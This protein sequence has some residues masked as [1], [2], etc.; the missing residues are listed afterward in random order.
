MKVLKYI[1]L[2]VLLLILALVLVVRSGS[3]LDFLLQNATKS[4]GIDLHYS[5]MSGN[6]WQGLVLED[7]NFENK[8]E[9]KRVALK[10][11]YP[12]LQKEIVH[13][14]N[15]EVLDLH[16]DEHFLQELIDSNSSKEESGSKKPL[17]FPKMVQIDNLDFSLNDTAYRDYRIESLQLHGENIRYD[18]DKKADGLITL[19][20]ATNVADLDANIT[21]DASHYTGRIVLDPKRDYLN[22]LLAE[23]NVT[24]AKAGHMVLDL[25]GDFEGSDFDVKI[26][27]AVLAYGKYMIEKSHI[28]SKGHYDF[29]TTALH[30]QNDIDLGTNIADLHS[31]SIVDLSVND[32]NNTLHFDV[33]LD[34]KGA[35]AELAEILADANLSFVKASDLK[36]HVAGS[37]QE[38]NATLNLKGG[39]VR[40]GAYRLNP[41]FLRIKGYYN[42]AQDLLDAKGGM[43]LRSN[44]ADAK[45]DFQASLSPKAWQKSLDL[46]LTGDVLPKEAFLKPQLLEQ[47]ITL[48][49]ISPLH[50][51][52][53]TRKNLITAKLLLQPFALVKDDLK[54]RSEDLRSDLTFDLDS[55]EADFTLNAPL[56]TNAADLLVDAN[57]S[58]DL[59]DL[60]NTL[61]YKAFVNL[62]A[63]EGY[64][65]KHLKIKRIDLHQLSPLRLDLTGDAKVLDAILGLHGK[66]RVDR[67]RFE[68]DFDN[69]KVHYNIAKKEV[70]S[71]LHIALLSTVADIKLKGRAAFALEDINNTFVHDIDLLLYQREPV[72]DVNLT[73]LG[74]VVLKSKGTLKKSEAILHSKKLNAEATLNDLNRINFTL[75]VEKLRPYELYADLPPTLKKSRVSMDAKGFYEIKS[76]KLELSAALKKL[77]LAGRDISTNRF[78]L[79]YDGK[80]FAMTPL[81]LQAKNFQMILDAKQESDGTLIAHLKN[82]A[83]NADVRFKEKPLFA[84]ATVDIS[85][86]KK[87]LHEVDKVYPIAPIPEVDGKVRLS[88]KMAGNERVKVTLVSPEISFKEGRIED[89]DILAYYTPKRI[90]IPRFDFTLAGFKPKKMN[91]K[92][93]LDHPAYIVLGDDLKVDFALKNFLTIKAE[94]SG[95]LIKGRFTT[96]KLF[97]GL[98]GYGETKLTSDIEL[99]KSGE[100]I[101]VS[102]DVELEETL[103]TYE[104]RVLD[105]SQDPDIIIIKKKRKKKAAD[106]SF[107][108]NVFLDLRIKSKDEIEYK[109]EAGT[110]MLKPNLEVRKDFGSKLK[111]LGKINILEGEYDF[112]D[113]RF[114]LKE[115]AIAFRGL[116]EINPHLDLH[117]E[118][119]IDEVVIYIDILGDKRKPKLQFKS[120]PMMSKK[121]IFSYLLFGFAVSESEGAQSSAANAAEKIFGRALAKDLARELKLD[122]L[123]LTRNQLGGI[124]IKAGKKVNKK[125]IIYYQNK[126]LESSV[127]VERK[128]GKHL[129]LDVE[130]GQESQAVDFV[131]RKGFK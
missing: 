81:K 49:K 109:V 69:T 30:A 16:I 108:K 52:A 95:D 87:L 28:A 120:K 55:Q 39:E 65:Q 91:R 92:V 90:D 76:K 31:S 97:L 23:Q 107:V 21:L 103:I 89:I 85:S 110:I 123:D 88:A 36:L 126:S 42:L 102:G 46:N 99:Y 72:M 32:I 18:I 10:I 64:L 118:Y 111:L 14:Q 94:K 8:V 22:P 45:L 62:K 25:D 112:G 131:Y 80:S 93:T 98:E 105:V 1:G 79:R 4:L 6:L 11:D 43:D 74:K 2:F 38:L 119:P 9:A 51:E 33:G 124:D 83:I 82:R 60:N 56:F 113:K 68:S 73:Q 47:N 77:H 37:L 96:R 86:I 63:K 3:A 125:T 127:I 44:A 19:Q 40:Y 130:I 50:I 41:Q 106:D 13:I 70:E 53:K 7:V 66:G 5:R 54:I 15:I 17:T 129:Q 26:D 58:V 48:Q 75:D 27:D 115:G 101:A 104:S 67:Y 57:G 117:V 114:Y 35:K 122:R 12:A 20:T 116:E 24:V 59:D 71:D 128:L 78:D 29:E 121:D 84:D 34:A 100:Q 61:R